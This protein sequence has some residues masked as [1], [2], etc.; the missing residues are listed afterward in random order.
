MS[1]SDAT[2][3]EAE[4]LWTLLGKPEW[5]LQVI[6]DAIQ[7]AE[8]RGQRAGVAVAVPKIMRLVGLLRR[9]RGHT[10]LRGDIDAAL[11]E[12]E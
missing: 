9:A 2:K 1:H 8:E 6:A 4:V 10:S 5:K 3:A 12:Y 7:A 11:R